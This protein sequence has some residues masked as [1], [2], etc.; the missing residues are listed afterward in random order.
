MIDINWGNYKAKFNGKEHSV[1]ELL[2]YMLFCYEYNIKVGIFR[3]KNQTGIETEPISVDGENISFQ[4]KYYD[5]S[6]AQN[7]N[8]I[9][10]S[11]AKAKSKNPDLNKILIY[12]NQEFSES[13][14]KAKKEPSYLSEIS[15]GTKK[16]NITIE[17]RLPSHIEKQ[18]S[19]PEND[20]LAQYFFS[21]STGVTDFL[22][23]I[24]SHTENIL[25]AIQTDI[26][27]KNQTIK[28]D[29]NN[30]L[31]D[32]Q[33]NNSQ[34]V[35]LSGDGG[36]GKTAVIKDLFK[37]FSSPFYVF[38]A[39][40]FYKPT[41]SSILAQFGN[42]SIDDFLRAHKDESKKIFVI[43]SAEKLA[44]LE[45]QDIFIE[46]LSA[47]IKDK[48]KV[49][50]TTRNSYLDDLG[51]Q[52][53]EVY[54]LPFETIRIANLKEDELK[55]LS[56]IHQFI[57][58]NDIRLQKLICNPFYLNEYLINYDTV[59]NQTDLTRFRDILW[60]KKIQNSKVQKNNVHREREKCFLI[61][62]KTRCDTGDFFVKGD[63]CN[64]QILSLLELDEIIRYEPSQGGF[65][66]THDIYE[67]WALEMLIEREYLSISSYLS[68][69]QS[70]G[71]SLPIRRAFRSWLSD[72]LLQIESGIGV[73]IEK[74]F[75]EKSIPSFWKDELLISIMLSDYSYTFFTNFEKLLLENKKQYLKKIIFLLRTA[76]K[77]IDSAVHKILQTSADSS[78]SPA[79]VFTKPKGKGWEAAIEYVF[80]KM[81]LMRRDELTYILPFLKDWV[82]KNRIGNTS[83]LAGLF[84]FHFYKQSELKD[85]VHYGSD[86]EELLLNIVLNSARELKSELIVVTE[87]LLN[88]TYNRREAFDNLRDAILTSNLDSVG[89]IVSLPDHVI[90]LAGASW[91]QLKETRHPFDTGGIGVEGYY[92][93]RSQWHQGYFPASALQTPIYYLLLVAFPQTINF[94]LDFT[95][96]TVEA[97]ANSEFDSSVHEIDVT[98]GDLKTKQYISGALWNIYRGTGSP[99]TPALLQSIHMALE[100]Y[101]LE[102]AKSTDKTIIEGWLIHMLKKTHSASITAVVTSIVLAYPEELFEVATIL[103]NNYE[104]FR[105]DNQRAGSEDRAKSLYSIGRGINW[106][107]KQF[108][109]ERI[110][111]CDDPH[112]KMSLENLALQ[113]QFFKRENTTDEEA[114]HRKTRIWEII[115]SLNLSIPPDQQES[116]KNKAIRLL[117]T[118]ID[119]RKMNPK[120]TRVNDNLVQIELNPVFSPELEKFKDEGIRE[121]VGRFKYTGLKLWAMNKFDPRTSTRPHPEYEDNPQNVIKETKE[122]L[123][124]LNSREADDFDFFDSEI[125]AYACAALI[126]LYNDKLSSDELLYCSEIILSYAVAPLSENYNYQ[127]ADGVEVAVSTLPFLYKIYPEKIK[128]YNI[129]LL[130][131]L[132][133][134]YP[135]GEYKRICDYVIEALKNNLFETFPD[136]A[137]IILLGYLALKPKF[138]LEY[139]PKLLWREG[140]SRT[141]ALN[142]F[143]DKYQHEL[144]NIDS[145]REYYDRIDFNTIGLRVAETGFQIIPFDT[146]NLFH[147]NFINKVLLKYSAEILAKTRYSDE[148]SEADYKLKHRF[149]RQYAKFLLHREISTIKEWTK[150]FIDAFTVSSEMADFFSD[151]ISEEIQLGKYESFWQIW[152]CF[153][154]TIKSI[155]KNSRHRDLDD[156]IRNYLL[157][158]PWWNDTAKDWRSLKQRETLFLKKVCSEMGSH[159]AV[160]FSI[161][162]L[163]NEV[164]SPFIAEG[165]TWIADM[166]LQNKNL[167]KEDLIPSTIYYLDIIIRKYVYLNRTMLK[168]NKIMKTKVLV[169]LDFLVAKGSV[170]GY[171]LREDIF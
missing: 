30:F 107:S 69:F 55:E 29:R 136:Q 145:T 33:N 37:D 104:F 100:K 7:K 65:F 154:P 56:D 23:N 126:K 131:I 76:C 139:S 63:D 144:E 41:L 130:L 20:Y 21:L 158:W 57:V 116:E 108:E 31:L 4:A 170:N 167:H 72:K 169:I 166:L 155:T 89:Y 160:L 38:K 152:E 2:A 10:D 71:N 32:L 62:A 163:L 138:N 120:T 157:A 64:N 119:R 127:I 112:R 61:L 148:K 48:W 9:I 143:I 142:E 50:F 137:N 124:K 109:D 73:F 98:I 117:L 53:L 16:L 78:I 111:S 153:Y 121:F 39:A 122:L 141:Q 106:K 54:R 14:K 67:E 22:N 147:L 84:A 164:G 90:R 8:D 66:I 40:E 45:S 146:N 86:N 77:E 27:F 58:P 103:F 99:V 115:D 51:F 134:A 94:I 105:Y 110:A 80:S 114:E 168:S 161:S 79:Y 140:K 92:S 125:P 47:L 5:T 165:I 3:F 118:R 15:K 135:I 46:F 123:E 42:Y 1:F 102:Q 159:P 75:T 162:K 18:L 59:N 81:D 17:W 13:S 43:D 34:I 97:Y 132:F 60:Q 91:F 113:Y 49:I 70:I 11:L 128:D 83:R 44:D 171:L 19:V 85:S 96:K 6:L 74:V 68:F 129:I 156:I 93:I 151:I 95:N 149:Y 52:M 133:D 87:K 28:I 35:I 36:S 82:D 26:S 150:P 101:L 25:F 88:D 24:K 12:T